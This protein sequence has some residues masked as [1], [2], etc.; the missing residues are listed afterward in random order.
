VGDQCC[1]NNFSKVL[2]VRQADEYVAGN[3][4]VAVKR[5]SD[6]GMFGLYA[7]K[8]FSAGSFIA[9]YTGV[10]KRN[11]SKDFIYNNYSF[12]IGEKGA[13]VDAEKEGNETRYIN[14]SCQPNSEY[15]DVACD[16]YSRGA[17]YA[18]HDIVTGDQV[19]VSYGWFVYSTPSLER[20][21]CLCGSVKCI[22][23]IEYVRHK[24]IEEDGNCQP[25]VVKRKKR[26]LSQQVCQVVRKE[27]SV[28]AVGTPE[29]VKDFIER[30]YGAMKPYNAQTLIIIHETLALLG[31]SIPNSI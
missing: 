24:K 31:Y 5:D 11:T 1:N 19:T 22:G 14:H 8:N 21:P 29:Y 7:T 2:S 4:G 9:E 6:S 15:R 20:R 28:S 17:V 10:L 18:V 25:P 16:G 23:Y 12:R 26:E 30:T 13:F 27:D 3:F